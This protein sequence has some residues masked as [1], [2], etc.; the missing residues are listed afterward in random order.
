LV[1][2]LHEFVD[3]ERR[4]LSMKKVVSLPSRGNEAGKKKYQCPQLVCYGNVVQLT[5]GGGGNGLDSDGQHTKHCWIAEVI[6]GVDAP[7]TQLVRAWLSECYERREPWSL[8]VLPLYRRFGQRI[9]VFLRRCPVFKSAFRP[10]FDLGVRRAHR[11][12]AAALL[13]TVGAANAAV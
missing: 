3:N 8:V 10:L 5:R 13:A 7:R 4:D 1:P 12:R 6:Y 2:I 9:A 11:D